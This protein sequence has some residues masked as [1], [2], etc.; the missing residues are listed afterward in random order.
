MNLQAALEAPRFTKVTFGG[1][2]LLMEDRI[3]AATREELARRA[4]SSKCWAITQLR[5]E[6]DSGHARHRRARELRRLRSAQR[7]AAVPEPAPYFRQENNLATNER[8]HTDRTKTVVPCSV[9]ATL[10][11][12]ME[13]LI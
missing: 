1:C 8:M 11:V 10:A 13:V 2:D 3:P 4:T 12:N 9:D 6:A 5:S 7:R